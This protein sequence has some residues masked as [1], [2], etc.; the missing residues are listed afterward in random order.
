M[1]VRLAVL[2]P[3]LWLL[4]VLPRMLAESSAAASPQVVPLIYEAAATY[5]VSG[6]WLLS[7]ALCETGGTLDHSL[8]GRSGEV[9]I[10]QWLPWDG[11]LWWSTP[12]G[13]LGISP[14]DLESNIAMAAWAFSV[15]LSFHWTCAR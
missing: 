12:A 7:V 6:A 9:G 13:R 1:I 8:R 2:I 3:A 10:F 5:G 15:G 14:W 11:S 4:L